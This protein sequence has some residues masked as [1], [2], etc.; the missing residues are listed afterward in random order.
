MSEAHRSPSGRGQIEARAPERPRL[1]RGLH[2]SVTFDRER[3][4]GWE[5]D[6]VAVILVDD[7]DHREKDA[8]QNFHV[9]ERI[10]S[11]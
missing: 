9:I 1:G 7:L 6:A 10:V 2:R 11:P 3:P 5:N 8:G 4:V